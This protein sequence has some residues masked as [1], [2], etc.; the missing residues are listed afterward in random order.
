[1]GVTPVK[2]C[3]TAQLA[4]VSLPAGK[5]V[6]LRN[7]QIAQIPTVVFQLLFAKRYHVLLVLILTCTYQ[8]QAL[9]EEIRVG[10][11]AE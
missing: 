10:I 1:L 3:L 11:R 4:K 9:F 8:I 7:P 5:L 6:S 2:H